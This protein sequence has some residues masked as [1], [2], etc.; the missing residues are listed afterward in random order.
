VNDKLL[1]VGECIIDKEYEFINSEAICEKFG[2]TVNILGF[3][4]SK[5]PLFL[6]LGFGEIT[7][8]G[9]LSKAGSI[10]RI[11]RYQKVQ[12]ES[13]FQKWHKIMK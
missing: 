9:Y 10:K 5:A 12:S 2:A 8:T 7:I 4:D 13:I 6:A 3:M 11:F 1:C